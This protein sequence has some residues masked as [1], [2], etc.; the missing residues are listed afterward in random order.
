MAKEMVQIR[1]APKYLP[2]LLAFATI[3][4]IIAVFVYFTI[5]EADKGNASI[6]GL[7]VTY[8]SAAGA[9]VG[10]VMALIL[11]GISRL[12]VKNAVAERSR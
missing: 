2:F 11:D 5:D 12:R 10:L 9:G 7:M 4:F 1:K 6:F 8:F 3:G